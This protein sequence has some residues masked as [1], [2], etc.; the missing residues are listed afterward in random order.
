MHIMPRSF[1]RP[2]LVLV[3]CLLPAAAQAQ[4]TPLSE[5]LPVLLGNTITLQPS[6][7]ADQPNHIAHFQPGADQVK[8]PEQVNE[9]LITLLS[10]YPIGTPGGGFTYVFDPALGTLTRSSNS[11]GPSFAE[12][13]LT[14]GRGK[15]SVGFA[16][17]HA[18][19]DTFEGLNLRQR[20]IV[21]F[22]P[23][24]DC[25]SPGSAGDSM[26]DGSRLTP[27]FEGDLLEAG[28]DLELV[29]DTSTVFATYGITNR[30]DVGL[31]VPFVHVK[32]DASVLARIQRLATALEPTVH[33]FEG[34]NPDQHVFSQGGS[35]TGLGDIFLRAKYRIPA[36]GLGVAAVG[37]A[38]VPTG[39]EINLLGTGG[40]QTRLL[41]VVSYDRGPFSPHLN[42]GYTFSSK[43][44]IPGATMHDEVVA[45]AGGDLALTSRVTMSFDVLGRTVLDAGRMRLTQKTFEF[46]MSGGGA[47][48]GGGGGGGGGGSGRPG[49][50]TTQ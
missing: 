34:G 47:G 42:L 13:A 23:H 35:A 24:T 12:R 43:G 17:Q 22:V 20:E 14:T 48:A 19:Y 2:A 21:F 4:G 31:A 26:P 41:G 28:L 6:N 27:P 29:S 7:L 44:A 1:V 9:A 16:Y 10:T 50:P 18:R 39:H 5:I 33:E 15:V 32:L 36:G 8:V 3:S 30:L 25:C 11:F 45:T 40:V 49:Q 46:A 38:R 37:E